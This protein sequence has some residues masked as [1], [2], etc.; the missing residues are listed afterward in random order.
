MA[1]NIHRHLQYNAWANGKLAEFLSAV[2]EKH[3]YT[4][5]KSSFPTLA[6]TVLHIWD[7]EVIWMQRLMGQHSDTW[8][9]KSFQGSVGDMLQGWEAG[10]NE[11][12]RFIA[13]K[14]N[15]WL[16][17][18]IEYRNM[19]GKPFSNTAADI[20]FH[21]VNHSTFH[22]GQLVTM[23]RELGYTRFEST[24]L[25]TWMRQQA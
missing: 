3:F 10:S 9:G 8:P 2:D 16:N 14:D 18:V 13:G 19:A 4:A 24:D 20:L 7:A 21:V 11:L 25:I 12:Q 23:M 1:H 5:L 17:G 6:G 22:R 15:E